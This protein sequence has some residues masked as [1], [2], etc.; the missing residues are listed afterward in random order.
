MKKFPT[1]ESVFAMDS[2]DGMHFMCSFMREGEIASC[3]KEMD[4]RDESWTAVYNSDWSICALKL[5][6]SFEESILFT[7]EIARFEADLT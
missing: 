2:I 6:L 1:T 5:P 3:V 7:L 4:L